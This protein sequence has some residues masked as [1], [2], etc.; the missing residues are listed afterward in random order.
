MSADSISRVEKSQS[1]D[2]QAY[3]LIKQAIIHCTLSPGEFV[4]EVRLADEM[5]ISKT[6]V[7]KAM[8]RL[9]QEGFLD[10][11]PYRGYSVAEISH[12]DVADIYKLRELLECHLVSVT[13]P[14]FSPQELDQIEHLIDR[15]DAALAIGASAEFVEFNREFHRTFAVK[16]GNQRIIDVLH[17]L[18]EHVRRIILYVLQNGHSDLLDLQR[19]DHRLI[20][21][22]MREGDVARTT[23]MM[24][25]H[26]R[27]FSEALVARLMH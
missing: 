21:L 7:R 15:A 13:T 26:L 16:N 14:H 17:N 1:L 2:E 3:E 6:P 23:S 24:R 12:Q 19:D 4:A 18:E 27:N 25:A 11:V 5:G 8:A 22:A 20:L 10:N 9:H